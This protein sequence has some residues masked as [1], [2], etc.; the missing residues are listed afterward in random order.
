MKIKKS[1]N[2]T[3]SIVEVDPDTAK[4]LL[5]DIL[6]EQRP[7]RHMAVER[8]AEEMKQGNWRLSSDCLVRIKGKLANGQHRLR[9]VILSGKTCLFLLMDTNDE[10]L[11]KV[12]DC[13]SR[14]TV[15]DVIGGEYA[16][17]IASTARLS[18]LFELGCVSSG[19]VGRGAI[20][21]TRSLCVEYVQ[22]HHAELLAHVVMAKKL[23]GKFRMLPTSLTAAV[24]YLAIQNGYNLSKVQQFIQNVFDGESKDDAARDFRE[25][26]IRSRVGGASLQR[27]HVMALMIKSL[28]SYVNG[29]R[30]SAVRL[31]EGEAFPSFK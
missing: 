8:L 24:S 4:E 11:Y 20:K 5:A 17:D 9:A 29:T 28:K 19:G 18:V 6:P 2:A 30:M 13:G 31:N 26:I 27:G 21:C 15:G 14:R 25:R 10:D 1:Q 22:Q 12:I 3:V 16:S 23:N 7:V